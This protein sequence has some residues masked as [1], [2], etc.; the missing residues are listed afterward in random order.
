[1]KEVFMLQLRFILLNSQDRVREDDVLFLTRIR[2]RR[3]YLMKL[4]LPGHVGTLSRKRLHHSH[5]IL[6]PQH[7]EVK[8]FL[9]IFIHL[10]TVQLQIFQTSPALYQQRTSLIL[11]ELPQID[12][13]EET[14]QLHHKR[15]KHENTRTKL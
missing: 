15:L 5:S 1:M 4:R 12:R 7:T 6:S 3:E 11:P 8:M 9:I 2:V 13:R 14:Q 10:L